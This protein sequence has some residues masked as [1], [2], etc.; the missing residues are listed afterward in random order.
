VGETSGDAA[1][2]ASMV[3]C[4]LVSEEASCFSENYFTI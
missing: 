4:V 1:E 3:F 2:V